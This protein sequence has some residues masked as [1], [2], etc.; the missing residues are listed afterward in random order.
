MSDR[1]LRVAVALGIPLVRLLARTWRVRETGRDGWHRCR[2]EGR[3]VVVCLWHGQMLALLPHHRDQNVA[4][5]IS[6]HRDGE[7][8]ARVVRAFGFRT[9]RGS[10][11]RG[12][13]RA[14]LELA[15]A[16]KRGEEIAITP[17]GP[18]GPRHAFAPGA[19]IAA[20]RSGA[21]VVSVV[22]HVDRAWQL[23]S[24]DAFVIP[25]PFARITV[26]YSDATTV[27]ATSPREAA[28]LTERFG[29]LMATLGDRARR[30]AEGRDGA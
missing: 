11:S 24:W 18:R 13:G 30:V 5:L 10:T 2:A 16:L 17:D 23:G 28:A 6:E 15:A 21:P 8:I 9:I 29:A 1:K 7:I 20:Q 22:A 14:L 4:V 12:G 27:D 3:A 19:L 25:K 26:A